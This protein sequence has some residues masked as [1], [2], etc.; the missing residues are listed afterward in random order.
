MPCPCPEQEL[1]ESVEIESGSIW[2]TD[3]VSEKNWRVEDDESEQPLA[4][5]RTSRGSPIAFGPALEYR[6]ITQAIKDSE[7]ILQLDD[8]WDGENSPRYN[9]W[10]WERATNFL[11]RQAS[12]AR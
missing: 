8:N 11:L 3:E 1:E 6:Q 7:S 10:T 12:L 2:I 9:R 5:R 4:K